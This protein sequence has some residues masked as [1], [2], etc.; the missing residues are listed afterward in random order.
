MKRWSGE[1]YGGTP[2]A[3]DRKCEGIFFFF[4][5]GASAPPREMSLSTAVRGT[6]L[7]NECVCFRLE[8]LFSTGTFQE[9]LL[10]SACLRFTSLNVP[11]ESTLQEHLLKST[12]RKKLPMQGNLSPEYEGRCI[13][14]RKFSSK[15]FVHTSSVDPSAP[16]RRD[17]YLCH[18]RDECGHCEGLKQTA[19]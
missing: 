2:C 7:M 10:K 14:I 16:T 4:L 1:C 18:M 12:L 17:A 13:H 15:C 11:L 19:I 8:V 5:S 3:T 9:C 6:V